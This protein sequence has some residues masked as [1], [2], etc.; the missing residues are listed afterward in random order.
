MEKKTE[1]RAVELVRAIRDQQ[2]EFLAGK[3]KAEIIAFFTKAGEHA[4]E[5]A[6]RK[7]K[8]AFIP[9][10]AADQEMEPIAS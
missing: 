5:E 2:A 9:S 8:S 7:R 3:S 6:R 1:I 10:V 4:G